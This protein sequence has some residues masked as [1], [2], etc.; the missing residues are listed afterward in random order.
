MERRTLTLQV[1]PRTE[2]TLRADG[3]GLTAAVFVQPGRDATAPVQVAHYWRP[4]R[5]CLP[6]TVRLDTDCLWIGS[7]AFAF[8]ADAA[9]KVAAFLTE[10]DVP[11]SVRA[12]QVAA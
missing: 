11:H 5:E 1:A 8:P 2:L 3:F 10:A 7:S 6:A 9:D 12:P 4:Q